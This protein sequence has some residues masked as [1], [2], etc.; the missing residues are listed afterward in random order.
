MRVHIAKILLVIRNSNSVTTRPPHFNEFR[1]PRHP[2]ITQDS[3]PLIDVVALA[4]AFVPR[5]QRPHDAAVRD[6]AKIGAK[7]TGCAP[8]TVGV[9]LMWLHPAFI[10][11]H[12]YPPIHT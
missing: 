7:L 5:L 3:L 4:D 11:W 2:G 6:L 10:S 1:F 12:A 8:S 9:T